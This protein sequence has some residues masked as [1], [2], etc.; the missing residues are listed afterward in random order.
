MQSAHCSRQ[1]LVPPLVNCD[2]LGNLT[3]YKTD[4]ER[5]QTL[6]HPRSINPN[7]INHVPQQLP[8]I[9]KVMY[10][11]CTRSNKNFVFVSSPMPRFKKLSKVRCQQPLVWHGSVAFPILPIHIANL[12]RLS[13]CNLPI[14]TIPKPLKLSNSQISYPIWHMSVPDVCVTSE[15]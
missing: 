4:V 10:V 7:M 1:P 2:Y 12:S 11:V 9:F 3:L 6:G 5:R 14:I 13:K 8:I 15:R